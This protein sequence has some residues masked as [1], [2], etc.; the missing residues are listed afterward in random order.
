MESSLRSLTEQLAARVGKSSH[1]LPPTDW[2]LPTDRKHFDNPQ[3]EHI[4]ADRLSI[5]PRLYIVK[6]CG[7]PKR[8]V[9]HYIRSVSY[10]DKRYPKE[11]G[12]CIQISYDGLSRWP[13]PRAQTSLENLALAEAGARPW[14]V[15]KSSARLSSLWNVS[16]AVIDVSFKWSTKIGFDIFET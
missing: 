3:D 5:Y 10:F 16:G 7:R 14:I 6:E 2:I 1:A 8:L 15:L 4:K 13:S 11:M 9:T 12:K